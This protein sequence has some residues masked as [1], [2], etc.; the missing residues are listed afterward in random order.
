M[1]RKSRKKNMNAHNADGYYYYAGEPITLLDRGDNSSE[2]SILN[3]Y[4]GIKH[5][6]EISVSYERNYEDQLEHRAGAVS[7][8]RTL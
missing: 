2:K 7:P 4:G 1:N 5:T 6:Q 8:G 3:R